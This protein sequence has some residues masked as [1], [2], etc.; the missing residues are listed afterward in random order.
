MSIPELSH[1]VKF[2][3]KIRLPAWPSTPAAIGCTWRI[4][5]SSYPMIHPR[6]TYAVRCEHS[7]QGCR[8]VGHA[9]RFPITMC[10]ESSL[11]GAVSTHLPSLRINCS[12]C[13]VHCADRSAC[14]RAKNSDCLK[15]RCLF[16]HCETLME[17]RSIRI[18][19][20]ATDVVR[21]CRGKTL[22]TQDSAL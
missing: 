11:D 17:L 8:K 19:K 6:S 22:S 21:R 5:S 16:K 1:S 20:D 4:A 14:I 9:G 13:C 12:R 3:P 18:S 10:A 2:H 15:R 7:R